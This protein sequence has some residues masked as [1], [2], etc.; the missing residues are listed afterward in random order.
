MAAT[1]L[2][3]YPSERRGLQMCRMCNQRNPQRHAGASRSSRRDFLKVSAATGAAAAGLNL[4]GASPAA[5]QA[6]DAPRDSGRPERR[7][8]IRGGHVMSMDPGVGDFVEADVLVEG[9]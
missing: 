7:Y 8:V 9:K 6:S 2:C 5:A 4:F 3:F 1:H